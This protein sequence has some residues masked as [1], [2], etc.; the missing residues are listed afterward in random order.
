MNSAAHTIA[1]CSMYWGMDRVN[2][3][4]SMIKFAPRISDSCRPGK[5][6]FRTLDPTAM[7]HIEYAA[8]IS[9]KSA[10]AF[11]L[12]RQTLTN[13]DKTRQLILAA[14]NFFYKKST[15]ASIILVAYKKKY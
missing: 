7:K 13:K 15:I 4:G 1:M 8:L 6:K 12:L 9:A 2:E 14:Q 3:R 10:P 5:Q 11:V